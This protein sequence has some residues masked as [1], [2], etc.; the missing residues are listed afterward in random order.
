MTITPTT[1]TTTTSITSVIPKLCPDCLE[2]MTIEVMYIHDQSDLTKLGPDY[3]KPDCYQVGTHACNRALFGV[4]LNGTFAGLGKLNN[5]GGIGGGNYNGANIC[6][7]YKNV[8]PNWSINTYSRYSKTIVSKALSK[9]IINNTPTGQNFVRVKMESAMQVGFP[10][11]ICDGNNQPHSDAAWFRI[12]SKNGDIIFNGCLSTANSQV[13]IYSCGICL[14]IQHRTKINPPAYDNRKASG[15]VM[16][17]YNNKPYYKITDDENNYKILGYI[18]WRNSQW[19]FHEKFTS[20]TGNPS[21]KFYGANNSSLSPFYPVQAGTWTE[22]TQTSAIDQK[23]I[24]GGTFGCICDEQDRKN[25]CNCEGLSHKKGL[26]PTEEN[27]FYD[28]YL[29][30]LKKIQDDRC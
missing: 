9:T 19:E 13:D 21:G 30:K 7:D 5:S 4:L 17:S 6:E 8:H 27:K 11:A 26:I 14:N 12:T 2:G 1:T 18:I 23:K 25:K 20:T 15:F 10:T 16:G 24:L 29:P 3:I 28:I 22:N